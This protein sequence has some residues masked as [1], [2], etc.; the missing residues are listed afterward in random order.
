[1]ILNCDMST[2]TATTADFNRPDT[3]LIDRENRAAIVAV[4]AGPVTLT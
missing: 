1:M 4:I 3:V 2:I